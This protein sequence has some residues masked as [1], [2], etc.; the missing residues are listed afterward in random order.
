MSHSTQPVFVRPG[1]HT[2]G[3]GIG[4]HDEIAAALH[5]R[6]GEAAAGVNTG[7]TVRC[8][9]SFASNVVVM[10][11][12][13]RMSF[14]GLARHHRLAAQHAVL[15]GERE[16]DQFELVLLDRGFDAARR[17]LLR[18]RPQTVALDETRGLM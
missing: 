7:N 1:Q 11:T 2:E 9:V 8:E 18:R 4:D 6:H 16:A 3:R 13:A 14:A 5:F 10:V 12:P 17:A 15:I